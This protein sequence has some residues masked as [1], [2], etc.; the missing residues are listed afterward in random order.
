M[1]LIRLE[2]LEFFAHHGY[3]HEEQKLGNRYSVDVELEADF[4]LAATEDDLT[5]TIN[6][7]GVYALIEDIMSRNTKLLEHLAHKINQGILK[8]FAGVQSVQVSVSKFNPPL[9]GICKAA[10][11]V[12][13]N[14]LLFIALA[15]LILGPWAP[16][17]P[18][19][20]LNQP[21]YRPRI[22]KKTNLCLN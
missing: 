1:G 18:K 12:L 7:E 14:V 9:K 13:I 16:T 17:C 5:G 10:T 4:G 20:A 8:D 19:F 21:Q 6:Y 15:F 11:V 2:G 22:C 3:H